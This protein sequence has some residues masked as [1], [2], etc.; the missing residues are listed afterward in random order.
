MKRF[1]CILLLLFST[2][3][4]Y[5]QRITASLSGDVSDPSGAAVP[6]AAV[7]ITNTGTSEVFSQTTDQGGRFLAPV[8]PPGHYDLSVEAPG[9][10]HLERKDLVLNV[11]QSASL[12]LTMELGK[13]AETVEVTGDAPLLETES[14]AL[15]QVV[16]NKSI[17]DLPLN[18]RNP[19]SLILLVPGVTGSSSAINNG[20]AFNV[21][22]GRQGTT[23]VLLDG[24]PS[25]PPNDSFN[26]LA[27]FPSVDAVQEFKV[28]TSGYS[29]EFGVSGG[30]I[31]NLLYKSESNQFHGSAYDFLRNSVMDANDFFSNRQG[32]SLASFKRNQFGFSLGGPVEIPKAYNG[33]NRTFFFADYEGLRQRAG[34]DGFDHCA[35]A[36]RAERRLL[37]GE[38]DGRQAGYDFRSDDHQAGKWRLRSPGV[39]RQPDS[40][41]P[42]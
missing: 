1:A 18:Q 14:S 11:D 26:A 29:A 39:R 7:H 4:A 22:G 42:D 6:N 9:F 41:Q 30:G 5:A 3:P 20:L 15:G 23:Q 40:L 27:I 34:H 38:D 12:K 36:S 17:V 19:F 21:N 2:L 16:N 37:A 10:K 13:A 31:I 33:R 25:A 24:V 32:V 35:D 8:L 28:Q